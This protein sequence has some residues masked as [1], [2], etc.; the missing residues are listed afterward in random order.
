MFLQLLLVLCPAVASGASSPLLSSVVASGASSPLLPP[1]VD[2]AS[3]L[4]TDSLALVQ[5][6]LGAQPLNPVS[7]QF[8]SDVWRAAVAM[9]LAMLREDDWRIRSNAILTLVNISKK[10]DVNVI[11]AVSRCVRDGNFFVRMNAV[12]ALV[13]LA[14]RDSRIL[15]IRLASVPSRPIANAIAVLDAVAR[16]KDEHEDLF[17][18]ANAV[19][20]LVYDLDT[21]HEYLVSVIS[22]SLLVSSEIPYER[23]FLMLPLLSAPGSCIRIDPEAL[24]SAQVVREILAL[25]WGTTDTVSTPWELPTPSPLREPVIEGSFPSRMFLNILNRLFER[26]L[27]TAIDEQHDEPLMIERQ[28]PAFS[29]LFGSIH[30]VDDLISQ[31][32]APD[33]GNIRRLELADPETQYHIASSLSR[34]ALQI[35]IS[36]ELIWDAWDWA[37]CIGVTIVGTWSDVTPLGIDGD[38]D[39]SICID[40]YFDVGLVEITFREEI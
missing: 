23:F 3:T 18:R 13:S 38:I 32:E 29:T 7:Q 9:A 10:D 2:S 26:E 14:S 17:V 27:Q 21:N 33:I 12:R 30:H 35:S 36:S 1:A 4:P 25:L 24:P 39:M 34:V 37:S 22:Q 20:E 40:V 16:L 19:R 5:I 11:E 8:D 31:L 28:S 15:P 6:M